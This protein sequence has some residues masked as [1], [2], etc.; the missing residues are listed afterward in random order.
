MNTRPSARPML[1]AH[2]L[3]ASTTPV[4][5]WWDRVVDQVFST[6]PRRRFRIKQWMISACVYA[7]S[8]C[9]LWFGL[10]QGWMY[11]NRLISWSSAL[12]I[13]MA[14]S[15]AALRSGW[16]E[17]FAD[18]AL[19]G[20][21]IV[22][23]VILVEWGYLICGP[24]RSVALFPL[25]LIFAFGAFSLTWRK[26]AWLTAFALVSLLATTT[27]LHATRSGGQDWSLRNADLRLDVTNVLM[28]MILLP[29]MSLVAARLSALR[30]K[31]RSERAALTQ[32]LAEVRRLAT[33]DELTGLANRRHMQDR[34]TQEHQ[35]F[36][37]IGQPFSIAI[38]DLDHFKHINDTRGHAGGDEV[39][40][41]F[42]VQALATVRACD[43]IARWG[44]EEFLLLMP[45]T[46]GA[47]A[48]ASVLRLLTHV[49]DG[50]L[51]AAPLSFSAGVTQ[52]REGE[53]VI[54]TVARADRTMYKAKRD[55]R[56]KVLLSE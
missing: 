4:R 19:T 7:A 31:L 5:V 14:A 1:F 35:R 46:V 39:L 49:R 28:I 6:D 9:V 23:G 48:Q 37:R 17:R 51:C 20:T 30:S 12:V 11:G 13:A 25:L 53:T 38:I 15:Y 43:L 21:Q 3:G 56:N 47:P 50:R 54:E 34:L 33:H 16:S 44:G 45:D 26:I 32:A 41:A 8:A 10:H 42:S 22:I 29:A 2:A 36:K 52:Y 24:V 40:Q 18:P 55:G 27:A